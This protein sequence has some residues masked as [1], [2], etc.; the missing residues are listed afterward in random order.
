MSEFNPYKPDQPYS[1]LDDLT[2]LLAEE[3]AADPLRQWMTDGGGAE[4]AE[5]LTPR[6]Y[7]LT[8]MLLDTLPAPDFPE[9]LPPKLLELWEEEDRHNG[10]LQSD[11]PQN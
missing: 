3:M 2:K 11:S 8:K 7:A 10:T 1:Q 5:A 9:G 4:E 6:E